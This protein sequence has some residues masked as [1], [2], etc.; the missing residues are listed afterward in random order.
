MRRTVP[1][2]RRHVG[3]FALCA[4]AAAV[5]LAVWSA[6]A[7][8]P[9]LGT[10]TGYAC[11]SRPSD[12]REL[13]FSVRGKVEE[14]FVRPGDALKTGDRVIRLDDLVQRQT[15]GLAQM[16]VDNTTPVRAAESTLAFRESEL[17]LT[18]TARGLEGA[19]ER[20][21]RMAL[22]ERDQAALKLEAAQ[23]EAAA[24]Q[25]AAE[26]QRARLEQMTI[27]SPI[28]CIVLEVHK[29]PGEAVDELTTVVTV[30]STDPLWLDV[31]V[32]TQAALGLSTGQPATVMWEDVEGVPE[33][34]G[35]IIFK[36]PAG[37]GGARQ[38]QVRVEVPNPGG[39]PSGLHG[40][41]RFPAGVAGPTGRTD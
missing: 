20:D 38:L 34:T 12:H 40:V 15:V 13:A 35:R 7:E 10:T 39:L 22:Y 1:V 36:S 14:L 31:N 21:L 37:H 16:Q 6:P 25:L 41:V 30:V 5:S 9:T 33:M 2:T 11:V 27:L 4:G 8:Q 28:N 29:R 24:N 26:Q 17:K 23:R 19:N 18:Q 32:P 3:P